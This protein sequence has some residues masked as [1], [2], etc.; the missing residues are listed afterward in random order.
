M[1]SSLFLLRKRDSI[2]KNIGGLCMRNE[3]FFPSS[4]GVTQIRAMEWIPEG[5]IKGIYQMCHG[6]V[7][8]IERYDAFAKYLA[9]KGYYVIGH[10]HLGHGKSITSLEN[11][12]FFHQEKGNACLIADIHKLRTLANEKYPDLPHFIM[13]HSMGS[14]LVRQYIGVHGKGLAGAVIMGTGDQPTMILKAGKLLCKTIALFKG[15]KYRSTFVNNMSIGAYAKVFANLTDGTSWLCRNPEIVKKYAEDPM[16]GFVFTISA[17]YHMYDGMLRMKQQEAAGKVPKD[18]PV[19]FV[20]GAVDPVGG[21]GTLVE[22]VY[23]QYVDCGIKNVSIKLYENDRH[24][25]LNELDKEMVYEDI[26]N[27]LSLN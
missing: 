9:S 12:G 16:C 10:D 6:M 3:F 25:I 8:H 1:L 15:W 27:F 2:N 19:F 26:L 23:K 17:Y 4:D 20:A 14:F 5:E 11:K 13:G 24:E 22:N 21:A 18:L 7:E